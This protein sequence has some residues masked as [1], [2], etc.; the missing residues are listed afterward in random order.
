MESIHPM[1]P[2]FSQVFLGER[3]PVGSPAA[4]R[5]G[6]VKAFNRLR[7]TA[8]PLARQIAVNYLALGIAEKLRETR[9]RNH[10]LESVIDGLCI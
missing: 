2:L 1:E 9:A 8:G 3:T 10:D 4:R 7:R 6:V 5:D